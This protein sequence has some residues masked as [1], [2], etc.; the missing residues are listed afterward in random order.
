MSTTENAKLAVASEMGDSGTKNP[1]CSRRGLGVVDRQAQGHDME[2]PVKTND[3][4]SLV[5]VGPLLEKTGAKVKVGTI[6]SGTSALKGHEAQNFLNPPPQDI[7]QILVQTVTP[8]DSKPHDH[9]AEGVF[10][11]AS[12][13][14][15]PP[16]VP[17]P[18]TNG[19]G[20]VLIPGK[21]LPQNLGLATPEY[22]LVDHSAPVPRQPANAI[23]GALQREE[24][25]QEYSP[26]LGK[27]IDWSDYSTIGSS[28]E[29][30]GQ[31]D[32]QSRVNQGYTYPRV[33]TSPGA[34]VS[35]PL[36]GI[37]QAPLDGGLI[38]PGS[39]T[40]KSFGCAANETEVAI[41]GP[42]STTVVIYGFEC[43]PEN[44]IH[45]DFTTEILRRKRELSR[46][47]TQWPRLLKNVEG[48][49]VSFNEMED[50]CGLLLRQQLKPGAR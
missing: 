29:E 49:L 15:R 39:A 7:P 9:L 23:P 40:V 1:V 36:R 37:S 41:Q 22:T 31:V 11:D 12:T 14:E 25:V 45:A 28:R 34:G 27:S 42:R 44:Y 3:G 17:G 38:N 48:P 20:T 4:G 5:V 10:E 19:Q 16:P 33:N 32:T 8:P 18:I 47:F 13:A 24:E 50:N 21:R 6:E 43:P 46:T 35:A 26:E 30:E 2:I